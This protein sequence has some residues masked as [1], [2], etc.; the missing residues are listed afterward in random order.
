MLERRPVRVQR[1]VVEGASRK[2]AVM[3]RGQPV[4]RSRLQVE[5]IQNLG[6]VAND[7][8][9]VT[10]FARP[11][12]YAKAASGLAA[13]YLRKVR[14]HAPRIRILVIRASRYSRISVAKALCTA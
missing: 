14:L 9:L 1:L 8:S 4:T 10:G 5:H 7:L 12:R 3:G 13:R 2:V 6:Q 11:P